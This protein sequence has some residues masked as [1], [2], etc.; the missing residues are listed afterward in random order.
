M[1]TINIIYALLSIIYSG[2]F[3][4][5]LAYTG[6]IIGEKYCPLVIVTLL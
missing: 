5:G 4:I 2:I 6:Q 3:V 1:S